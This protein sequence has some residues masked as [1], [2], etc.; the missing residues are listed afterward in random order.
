MGGGVRML[1]RGCCRLGG[2]F[3]FFT[4]PSSCLSR[5]FISAAHICLLDSGQVR[6]GQYAIA[7]PPPVWA[8]L[9]RHRP[10]STRLLINKMHHMHVMFFLLAYLLWIQ[11]KSTPLP[12][13]RLAW[14]CASRETKKNG[15]V[16]RVGNPRKCHNLTLWTFSPLARLS[17]SSTKLVWGFGGCERGRGGI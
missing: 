8:T 16:T 3:G 9:D 7:S 15:I 1:E 4:S 12:I 6:R 11:N 5:L 17:A 2:C 13:S 14:R 10:S